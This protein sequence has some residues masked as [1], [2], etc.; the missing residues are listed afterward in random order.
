MTKKL[1]IAAGA[2]AALA[3]GA[4]AEALDFRRP[5]IV[6]Q[7]MELSYEAATAVRIDGQT[8]FAVACPEP[9]AA[10]WVKDRVK[11]WFGVAGAKVS[12]VSAEGYGGGAGGV[13]SPGR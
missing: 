3:L 5:E 7:P 9:G 6:P 13:W 1:V 8:E 2:F 11:A 12:S 4:S 10:E